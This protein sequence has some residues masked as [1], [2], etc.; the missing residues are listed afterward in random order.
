[1]DRLVT[2]VDVW[3]TSTK[4]CEDAGRCQGGAGAGRDW[5]RRSARRDRGPGAAERGQV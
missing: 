1:V 4:R 5:G 2:L 3:I